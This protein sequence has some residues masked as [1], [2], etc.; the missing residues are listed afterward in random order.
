MKNRLWILI[1]FILLIAIIGIYIA[2]FRIFDINQ[3]VRDYLTEK[4]SKSL[5]ADF[6]SNSVSILPWSIRINDV[7]LR[8]KNSPLGVEAKRIRIG[9]NIFT[10]L[11]NRFQPL[12]STQKIFIDE[13]EFTWLFDDELQI[14]ENLNFEKKFDI[15]IENFQ[16]ININS[17]NIENGSFVFQRGYSTLVFVDNISG[18]LAGYKTSLMNINIEGKVLSN[19]INTKC[20]GVIDKANNSISVDIV[21]NE[22]NLAYDDIEVLSGDIHPESGT[23]DFDIHIKNADEKL[24]FYGNYSVRDGSFLFKDLKISA[25]NLYMKGHLSEQEVFLDSFSGNVLGVTP[26]LSC[27]IKLK[28]EPTLNLVL[29][30]DRVDVSKA[31]SDFFPE[32]EVYP[33]GSMNIS[34]TLRGPLRNLTAKADLYLSSLMYKNELIRDITMKMNIVKSS[35]EFESFNALYHGYSFK[36]K[37]ISKNTTGKKSKDFNLAFTASNIMETE[38]SF[39]IRL[40][41]ET[42]P[43]KNAYYSD[44][45]LRIKNIQEPITGNLSYVNDKV[46]YSIR[47]KLFTLNGSINNVF[48]DAEIESIINFSNFPVMKYLGF[49]EKA[50]FVNGKGNIQGNFDEIMVDGE[51]RLLWG[52]N[53]NSMLIGSATFENIFKKSRAFTVDA[54]LIDHHLRYSRPMTWDL[55]VKSD[56]LGIHSIIKES[57]GASL[58]LNLTPD[59][60]VLS[61]HLDLDEFPLEW[62]ID[63]FERNEFSHRG[64]LTGKVVI[65]GTINDPYF[66]T[67]EGV[68]V[69]E[70]KL[71]GLDRLNG[72]GY[73]SGR[74]GELFFSNMN[75]NRDEHHIMHA[76]GKWESGKPFILEAQGENV[77]LEAISDILSGTR[78][79]DGRTEYSIKTVF[80]RKSGTIDGEFTVRDGHFLDIPF[81]AASG[82]LGGGSEGFRVTNFKI[83][84]D[85]IF[86]GKGDASSGYL[87]KNNTENPGLRMNLS[88]NGDLIRVLPHIT[89]ALK[90]ASGESRLDLTFGGTWQEPMILD[91][92]VS[93]KNGILE[94]SFLVDKITNVNAV[95]KIDPEFETVSAMKAVR[96]I[97]SSGYI[98]DK[99]IIVENVHVDDETWDQLKR[100]ELLGVEYE[101]A[102]L[103]FGVF[104]V[105]ID[106]R[107]NRDNSIELHIPGFMRENE[108]GIFEVSGIVGD[109]VLVGVSDTGE[110]M[111][112]YISGKVTVLSGDINYP[113]IPI[114]SDDDRMDND[115]DDI[116][117]LEEIFWDLEINIGTNVNY[118]KEKNLGI[119][120]IAGTTLWQNEIKI[121]KN[122]YFTVNGRLSDG[123]FRVAGNARSTYGMV[124]YYGYRFDIEWADLELDTANVL[125]PAIITGRARTIVFDDSTGVETEIFLHVNFVDRESGKIK[126][127]RG[128]ARIRDNDYYNLNR[129]QT[130]F[131]A[132]ALGIIEIWFSSSNPSDNTQNKILA[133]LGISFDNIGAAA[134]RAL[135]SGIDNYYLNPLLRPFEERIKK[136]LRVDMVKIT[137]SFL[138][139]FA[140]SRLGLYSGYNSG[141]D[142]IY[143]KRSSIMVGEHLT[144][145]WFISYT[146]QYGVGRDFLHRREKGFYHDIELQYLLERNI[147]LQLKY[148]YDEIINQE[149]KRIEFR[150]DFEFE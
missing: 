72:T 132:G 87:W 49:G 97:N 7:S 59:D 119:G 86:T 52:K 64:K 15:L 142:Y 114:T 137:P 73:V 134:T 19:K 91:G 39:S 106:K 22:C 139:N 144:K 46:G 36:G 124:T 44:I 80:T 50:L 110:S 102:N 140:Q 98:G 18:W 100:P 129:L 125:K 84:K 78:K 128:D 62:I 118:V 66:E 56:T 117:I 83:E 32:I 1:M 61:G 48:K 26:E 60:R 116:N 45:D 10:L 20:K 6:A 31:L 127:A 101:K 76:E 126:E 115:K 136:V 38:K 104:T 79:T 25:S 11:K 143:L 145:D 74:P 29:N 135:T 55:S 146:G 107:E 70:L 150:Y 16:S 89:G 8:L 51:F 23:L 42:D 113:L 67:P 133:R 147:R 112:P 30:A 65:G 85:G 12:Y 54:Q 47:N 81:D 108:T 14:P 41:G 28:P 17:I 69:T 63:I 77:E 58:V 93:V 92:E 130:R 75:I 138:G 53:L 5:D 37:G 71:G 40:N 148:N 105:I 103:D 149:D 122:S 111:T 90:R 141:T 43:Q 34:A 2:A 95:L 82:V 57:E 3:K 4:I 27:N 96:I 68:S 35:L 9:F 123:S 88:L 21:S 24:A 109:K 120:R 121:D 33:E 13:P 94:P 131:D 99:R